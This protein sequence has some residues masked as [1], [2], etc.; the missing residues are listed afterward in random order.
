MKLLFEFLPIF[1]LFGL[2]KAYDIKIATAGFMVSLIVLLFW[3]YYQTRKWDK[4]LLATSAIGLVLGG[5][6]LILNNPLYIQHKPTAV[7]GAMALFFWISYAIFNKNWIALLY[8]KVVKISDKTA[9]TLLIGTIFFF[10]LMLVIN[11]ILVKSVNFDLWITI[12][13]WGFLLATI[14]FAGWQGYI[15]YQDQNQQKIIHN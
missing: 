8:S 15:I 4:F 13:T 6:T 5:A 11:M 10:L 3:K 7:Y 12:K 9:K 1:V 14:I 2:Y